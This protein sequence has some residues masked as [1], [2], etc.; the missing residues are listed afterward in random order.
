MDSVTEPAAPTGAADAAAGAV[1]KDESPFNSRMRL[2]ASFLGPLRRW[3]RRELVATVDQLAVLS[4]VQDEGQFSG[5]FVFM[6]LMSGG[7]AILGL[8]LSS[9]AVVIG[10]M[11][12]SPLMGPIIA[13]GFALATGDVHWLKRSARTL[14]T[15]ALAA[16]LFC[17]LIVFMSPLQTVTPEIAARTRP[18]LFDLA[19]AIFSA[20][21]GT[22][23]MIRG[24]EGAIVGVA[25]ATALMPPLA[26]VGF[27]LATWNWTVFT[28]ALMLFLTNLVA[29]ALFAT[30]MARIYGFHSLLTSRQ[31]LW[32]SA[33]IVVS[34]IALAVPLTISLLQIAGEANASR[35]INGF[36]KDEF[37]PRARISQM[38]IDYSGKTI[39]VTASVLT[40]KLLPDVEKTSD[41][42]L[43]R[44]LGKPVK[45]SINQ[46]RVGTSAT[47]AEEAQLA[48]ART[49]QQQ[50]EAEKIG[51]LV[52]AMSLVSGVPSDQVLVDREHRKI[53]VNAQAIPGMPL[54]AYAVLEARVALLAPEWQI[55]L[56]PPAA[57]LPRIAF[58]DGKP[59]SSGETALGLIAWA[60]TRV[61]APVRLT[62][63]D[64]AEVNAAADALRAKG[65]TVLTERGGAKGTVTAAWA[66]PAEAPGGA[67]ANGG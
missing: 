37:D 63:R 42:A 19:I 51:R 65:V 6:L 29:I 16:I 49:K 41:R 18:N 55:V 11:L 58:A 4:K 48:A 47:D 43:T 67:D 53:L 40:P 59:E 50:D 30:I 13:T 3:R 33:G 8:L 14:L 10:A 7:I 20:L 60:A 22:Y 2:I 27:G 64:D 46:F 57:A 62:G 66:S 45:V 26:T 52:E 5:R 38:D 61:E 36:I 35:T 34:L 28:G 1:D 25:I 54:A 21:A 12:I 39:A 56:R 32:Q 17:A 9:P 15:G 23:A 31:T 44:L 24:R